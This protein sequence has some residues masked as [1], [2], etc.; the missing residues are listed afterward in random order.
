MKKIIYMGVLCLVLL[1][2]VLGCGDNGSGSK[3]ELEMGAAAVAALT[4]R[5]IENCVDTLEILAS[6]EEVQSA[7]WEVMLPVLSRANDVMVPGPKWFALPDGSYY[8]VGMGK[9]DKNI[10][11]R[12]YFPVVMSGSNTYS[13]LVVSRSTGEK[14][15]VVAVPVVKSGEVIGVVGISVFLK[16]L[17]DIITEELKLVDDIVFYAVTPADQVALHLDAALILE[18]SPQPPENAVSVTAAFTGWRITLGY[19]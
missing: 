16:D 19:R 12:A 17:S 7:N 18:E 13:E 4:D 3:S 15:L 5:H 11:D 1:V 6:T 14:V 8:V 9:T 10:L 2:A